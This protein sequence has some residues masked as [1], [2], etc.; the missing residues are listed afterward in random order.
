MLRMTARCAKLMFFQVSK[1]SL[2]LGQ[3][4]I[5]LGVSHG[6][7]RLENLAIGGIDTLISHGVIYFLSNVLSE[8]LPW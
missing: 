8:G 3:R 2:G 4:L 1:T 6:V 5:K 7:E